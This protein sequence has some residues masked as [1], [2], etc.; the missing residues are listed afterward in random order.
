M[1][2][3]VLQSLDSNLEQK[4]IKPRLFPLLNSVQSSI[5][6]KTKEQKGDLLGNRS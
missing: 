3:C 1:A 2:V 5:M 4:A 6:K